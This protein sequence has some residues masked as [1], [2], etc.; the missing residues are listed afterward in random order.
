MSF[1]YIAKNLPVIPANQEKTGYEANVFPV[2]RKSQ[3]YVNNIGE[4]VAGFG[5]K[6]G[7][8]DDFFTIWKMDENVGG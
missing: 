7:T 2:Y 8:E 3:S 1:V 5:E 4:K 6:L